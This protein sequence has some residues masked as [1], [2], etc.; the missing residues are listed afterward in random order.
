MAQVSCPGTS[1]SCCQARTAPVRSASVEPS[2]AVLC[3][4]R[5][6]VEVYDDWDCDYDRGDRDH[7]RSDRYHCDRDYEREGGLGYHRRAL[8]RKRSPVRYVSDRSDSEDNASQGAGGSMT[9]AK[10]AKRLA[11]LEESNKEA[12]KE[13]AVK[14]KLRTFQESSLGNVKCHKDHNAL[15]YQ[16]LA[17]LI[18]CL[19]FVQAGLKETQAK[20][21]VDCDA[22]LEFA[23]V[24]YHLSKLQ[25]ASLLVSDKAELGLRHAVACFNAMADHVG[26]PKRLKERARTD[27]AVVNSSE[28]TRILAQNPV[29]KAGNAG[30]NGGGRGGNNHGRGGNGCGNGNGG[31]GGRGG[32]Q[33]GP[34]FNPNECTGP[35]HN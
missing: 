35:E 33:G 5:E 17:D 30:G 13:E 7:D 28:L 32:G 19:D 29:E 24:G 6:C 21:G 3:E 4:P 15:A 1:Y 9:V 8:E 16:L 31:N 12:L 26:R 27:F 2:A 18:E 23:T 25:Y 20:C 10:L 11:Q 22:L 14:Q 34:W